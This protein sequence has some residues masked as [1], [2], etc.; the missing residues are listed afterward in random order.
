MTT[1][2]RCLFS[3]TLDHPWLTCRPSMKA[4]LTAIVR[5]CEEGFVAI[6]AEVPG[7]EVV[8][9]TEEDALE[10]LI[11]AIGI[12]FEVNRNDALKGVGRTAKQYRIVVESDSLLEPGISGESNR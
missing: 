3:L 12:V 9:A 10:S 5:P 1:Q 8:S 11:E 7:A 6:C 2:N 4:T